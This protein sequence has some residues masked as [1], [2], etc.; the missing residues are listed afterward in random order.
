MK[1][2][3]IAIVMLCASVAFAAR[4]SARF[5]PCWATR[6]K[7]GILVDASHPKNFL[8]ISR[9]ASALPFG[10]APPAGVMSRAIL[11]RLVNW[12]RV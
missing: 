12:R 11:T 10:T 3:L 9:L 2:F 4:C 8:A 7:P 5:D 1:S 6:F